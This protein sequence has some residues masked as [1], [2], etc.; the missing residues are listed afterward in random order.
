M[1]KETQVKLQVLEIKKTAPDDIGVINPAFDLT[2]P[3]LISGIIT[4]KGVIK[5]PYEESI[6]KLFG[7]N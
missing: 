1:N 2:T 4:E 7:A 6:T 5:P 3:D